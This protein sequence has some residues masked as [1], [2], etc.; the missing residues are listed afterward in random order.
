MKASKDLKEF[1]GILEEFGEICRIQ[2]EV[3]SQNYELSSF[4][5]HMEDGPRKEERYG[6]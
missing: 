1:I 5:R 6:L 4:I 2:K 3:D